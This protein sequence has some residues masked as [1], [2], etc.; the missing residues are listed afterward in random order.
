MFFEKDKA[1]VLL[2]SGLWAHPFT[3]ATGVQ[4]PLGTPIKSITYKKILSKIS[5]GYKI[6]I[7]NGFSITLLKPFSLETG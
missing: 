3:P 2:I 7:Q 5:A 6:R 4:I 1:S